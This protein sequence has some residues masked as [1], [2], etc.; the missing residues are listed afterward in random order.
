MA[1]LLDDLP[2]PVITIT[3]RIYYKVTIHC[4]KCGAVAL[5]RHVTEIHDCLSDFVTAQLM[6][7]FNRSMPNI[8]VGWAMSGRDKL[9][10]SSCM[11]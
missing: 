8:P 9:T 2:K 1:G 4:H 11:K 5:S 10:C 3:S 7:D 6:A